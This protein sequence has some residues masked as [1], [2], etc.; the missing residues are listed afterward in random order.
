MPTFSDVHALRY[1]YVGSLRR[2]SAL[3]K[4]PVQRPLCRELLLPLARVFPAQPH[5]AKDVHPFFVTVPAQ[6]ICISLC[7]CRAVDRMF[8]RLAD[9][10]YQTNGDQARFVRVCSVFGCWLCP[11]GEGHKMPLKHDNR[12]APSALCYLLR[13]LFTTGATDCLHPPIC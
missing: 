10:S 5:A 4:P 7:S 13:A 2:C 12:A 1:K 8:N 3:T 9:T 6:Q 11:V